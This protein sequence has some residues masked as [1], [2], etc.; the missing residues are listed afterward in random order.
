MHPNEGSLAIRVYAMKDGLHVCVVE[1]KKNE[2]IGSG[3]YQ[4]WVA[5]T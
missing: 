2:R 3:R 4:V 1:V 5:S